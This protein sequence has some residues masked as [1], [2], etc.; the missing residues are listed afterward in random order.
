MVTIPLAVL[1]DFFITLGSAVKYDA[2]VLFGGEQVNDADSIV[3]NLDFLFSVSA[4]L[5]GSV[6]K[7]LINQI[8]KHFCGQ[9]LGIGVLANVGKKLFEILQFF[10]TVLDIMS[11][12]KTLSLSL[13]FSA[14]FY[15]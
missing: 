15:K 6:D 14:R 8:V 5:I 10:L 2:I 9:F 11:V 1:Y 7:H 12:L 13:R 4:T 3:V